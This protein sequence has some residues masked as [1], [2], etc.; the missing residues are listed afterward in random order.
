MYIRSAAWVCIY[1]RLHRQMV[2]GVMASRGDVGDDK[3]DSH[4][5]RHRRQRH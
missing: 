1:V 3:I 4:W 5:H 2:T